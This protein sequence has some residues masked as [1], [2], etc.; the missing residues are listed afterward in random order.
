MTK[1][2]IDQNGEIG[3]LA[4]ASGYAMKAKPAPEERVKKEYRIRNIM[5]IFFP[6]LNE[7]V[8]HSYK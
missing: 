5:N 6:P 1:N 7:L 3:S 2:N 8:K 4:T